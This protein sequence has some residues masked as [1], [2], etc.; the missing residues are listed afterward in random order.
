[1][2]AERPCKTKRAVSALSLF[3]NPTTLAAHA[4]SINA[5]SFGKVS[6]KILVVLPEKWEG[7]HHVAVRSL[8]LLT[9]NRAVKD[10]AVT[11]TNPTYTLYLLASAKMSLL[12]LPELLLC[13]SKAS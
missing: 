3:D 12:M 11:L 1:M 13:D 4:S 2:F 8:R 6:D 9:T 7:Q 10:F 5:T